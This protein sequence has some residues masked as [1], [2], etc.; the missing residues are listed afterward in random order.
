MPKSCWHFFRC[1]IVFFYL[2]FIYCP[3]KFCKIRH[4][5]YK[6]FAIFWFWVKNIYLKKK[7]KSLNTDKNTFVVT[8]SN[9]CLL[10]PWWHLQTNF[11]LNKTGPKK[12]IIETNTCLPSFLSV[13]TALFPITQ[14]KHCICLA[15][16]FFTGSFS[17]KK[18][19]I[20][21]A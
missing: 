15:K 14:E 3:L 19:L 18:W 6:Y 12:I 21:V 16:P 4:L 7:K 2:L 8:V 20:F 10:R 9:C 5:N 1:V 13:S 11:R 17:Y